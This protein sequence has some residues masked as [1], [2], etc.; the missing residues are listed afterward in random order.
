MLRTILKPRN[1]LYAVVGLLLVIQL[2]P[3]W[4]WQTNPPAQAQPAWN[5]PQTEAL[6]RRACYD[7]HSNETTWPLYSRIAPVSWR[8]TRDV[9][10]G[11]RELNFSTWGIPNPSGQEGRGAGGEGRP[12]GGEGRR[13]QQNVCTDVP[14]APRAGNRAA[15]DVL[16]GEMPPWFYLPL[17]ATAKLTDAEKQQ[18]VQG[19][20]ASLR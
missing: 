13:V 6:A 11:R 8:I 17:H 12:E 15:R 5:D 3:V 2:F 1:I 4:L 9:V 14:S 18:L 16:S 7:C 19:L 10:E 20:C